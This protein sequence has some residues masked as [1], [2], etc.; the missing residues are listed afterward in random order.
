M[1]HLATNHE[2]VKDFRITL[3]RLGPKPRMRGVRAALLYGDDP[4]HGDGK[5]W[6]PGSAPQALRAVDQKWRLLMAA[7]C[8]AAAR[9]AGW[10]PGDPNYTHHSTSS[11]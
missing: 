8:V 6:L 2:R 7:G 9:E 10:A 3:D 11:L 4:E 5:R 1:P